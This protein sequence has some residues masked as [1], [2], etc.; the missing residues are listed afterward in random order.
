VLR[1]DLQFV[2]GKVKGCFYCNNAPTRKTCPNCP[3]NQNL[4]KSEL[5]NLIWEQKNCN[6]SIQM[7]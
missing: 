1:D 2:A 7:E 5:L 6:E 3:V 4:D